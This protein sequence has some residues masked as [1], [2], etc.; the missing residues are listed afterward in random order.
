[1]AKAASNNS[2]GQCQ[3]TEKPS[4]R[5]STLQ[6][7]KAIA[8]CC[9]YIDSMRFDGA[10]AATCKPRSRCCNCGTVGVLHLVQ[11]PDTPPNVRVL[12]THQPE[13]SVCI[14]DK[15]G[16]VGVDIA[17]DGVHAS[18]LVVAGNDLQVVVNSAQV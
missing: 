4:R 5:Q 11:L 16:L 13:Q 3:G 17:D 12:S 2:S 9:M 6:V 1:M 15:V 14:E 18:Y 7:E 8:D 10:S